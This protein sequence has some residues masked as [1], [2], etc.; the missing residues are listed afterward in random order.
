MDPATLKAL[1]G[2]AATFMGS[3]AVARLL[4]PYQVRRLAEANREKA[5]LEARTEGEVALIREE[6]KLAVEK[7]RLGAAQE[8]REL[9]A[10]QLP[11]ANVSDVQTG[12]VLDAEYEVTDD[13]P[14]LLQ[15]AHER[16]TLQ[17]AKRQVNLE[18]VVLEAAEEI[19]DEKRTEEK[20]VD[21]DWTARFFDYAKDVSNEDMQKLWAKLLAGEVLT[22][23]RFSLRTLD[24]VRNLSRSDAET[25]MQFCSYVVDGAIVYQAILD[26]SGVFPHVR[27]MQ[28]TEAGLIY[29]DSSLGFN[30]TV[31]A[32]LDVNLTDMIIRLTPMGKFQTSVS[33]Y[34]LTQVGAE[35]CQVLAVPASSDYVRAVVAWYRG[36]GSTVK[37]F[38][39]GE[40]GGIDSDDLFPP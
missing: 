8:L 7:H 13:G 26:K 30:W 18:N 2:A 4:E 19:G 39:R 28:L 35:L 34:K 6:G 17:E 15:R 27:I 14:K 5:L 1:G 16:Q 37:T 22:P 31:S 12:E 3:T 9:E 24:V 33:A 36:L 21:P 40:D 38:A 23:G 10:K 32:P 20:P 11:P 25:F 29:G